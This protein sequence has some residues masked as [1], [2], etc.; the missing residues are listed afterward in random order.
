MAAWTAR[1]LLFA[2]GDNGATRLDA[3]RRHPAARRLLR[4]LLR[5]RPDLRGSAAPPDL[6]AAAQGLIAF[7]TLGV[8]MFIGSWVQGAS[9][10]RSRLPGGGHA[11]DRIWLVPAAWRGAVLLLF[12]AF[13]RAS[14]PAAARAHS[15]AMTSGT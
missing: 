9:S 1:Y 5:H 14:D 13:F 12:A 10:M 6:R 11:W 7:V 15:R 4:L 8:G 3:L 2:F